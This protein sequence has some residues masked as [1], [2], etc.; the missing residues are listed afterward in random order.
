MQV[1]PAGDHET[2]PF[3]GERAKLGEGV[4]RIAL[5]DVELNTELAANAFKAPR[6][7]EKLP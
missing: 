4:I 2:S 7:A 5:R 6:R 1:D 3:P